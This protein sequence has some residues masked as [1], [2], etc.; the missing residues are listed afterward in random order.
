MLSLPDA[1]C[2]VERVALERA[3]CNQGTSMVNG[4]RRAT[5]IGWLRAGCVWLAM[6]ASCCAASSNEQATGLATYLDAS[7]RLALPEGFSGRL[8]PAGFTL[9]SGQGEAPRFAP[10]PKRGAPASRWASD[11]RA[12]N[13]CENVYAMLVA[14]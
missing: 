3:T 14:P 2:V 13:G 5:A 8:D 9:V 4:L 7:G 12:P 11:F 10:A 1:H 6:A